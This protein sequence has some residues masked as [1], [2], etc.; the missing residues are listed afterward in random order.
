MRHT[1]E[2]TYFSLSLS[3]A[4][5]IFNYNLLSIFLLEHKIVFSSIFLIDV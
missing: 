3:E 2:N 4:E 5:I 1:F